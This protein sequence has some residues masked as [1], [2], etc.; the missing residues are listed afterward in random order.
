MQ[1]GAIQRAEVGSVFRT[2]CTNAKYFAVHRNKA[3][4]LT[5]ENAVT[6][7]NKHALS[8]LSSLPIWRIK[9][10]EGEQGTRFIKKVSSCQ[11]YGERCL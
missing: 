7:A 8:V 9:I 4:K 6:Y 2:L 10:F 1:L 5:R 3:K 11:M